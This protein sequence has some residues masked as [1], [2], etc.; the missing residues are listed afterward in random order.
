LGAGLQPL[1]KYAVRGAYKL[2]QK[3]R[4]VIAEAQ[5]Q[6]NDIVAEVNAEQEAAVGSLEGS[7]NA[8]RPH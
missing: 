1:A 4:E 6:V 5:E 2:G 3:T 8:T 7:A